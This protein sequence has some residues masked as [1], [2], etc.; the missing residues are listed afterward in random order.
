MTEAKKSA[1]TIEIDVADC[2]DAKVLVVDDDILVRKLVSKILQRGGL[3][4]DTAQSGAEA[5][6]LLPQSAPD[7]ILCDIMM[8]GMDGIEF[9]RR[10]RES[11]TYADLPL[12]FFTGLSDM[13]TLSKGFAAGGN[14]YVVKPIRQVEVLSRARHHIAEY[15][16]KQKAK[17]KISTLNQQNE[18][19]TKFLGVASHD[20]R[21]PLVSIRG[22]S[23]YLETEK[24]GPLNDGQRE[25][26]STI[27]QASEAMLTL[28]EDL[29]DVS[30][31]EGGHMRLERKIE[32]L[33]DL[34][35]AA[36]TLH[37]ASAERKSIVLRKEVA[38]A[39]SDVFVDRRLVARVIDNL[40]TNAIKFSP[41]NT[42]VTLSIHGNSESVMLRVDDEGPGIPPK[43]F[44]KLFKE[45]S[46]T[47][48]Q[49]T[50]GESSNGIGLFVSKRI[51][52]SH[53]GS[54]G[55]ENRTD[56]GARFTITFNRP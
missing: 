36:I 48:N 1:Q 45:F 23:Q 33:E 51:M 13:Q 7:L 20:L 11:D 12:I 9:C 18:S 22:I 6:S 47:S 43:E 30:K 2:A 31:I 14:D 10:L 26:V 28:V 42:C 5:L 40:V 44:G 4:C 50:G 19:K 46:R 54:I 56:K 17:Q 38:E 24:F 15:R 34:A 55:V 35:S 39:N 3:A 49:P 53:G 8:P 41:Q 21:N 52:E 16:R 29:L 27:I 32:S 37:S 25:L